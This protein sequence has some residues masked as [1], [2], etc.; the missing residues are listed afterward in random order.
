MVDERPL[1]ALKRVERLTPPRELT[2]Q[3]TQ[4]ETIKRKNE[5]KARRLREALELAK[6]ARPRRA[7]LPA[8]AMEDAPSSLRR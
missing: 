1:S 5:R 4:E 8:V 2:T 6:K 3:L 7:R